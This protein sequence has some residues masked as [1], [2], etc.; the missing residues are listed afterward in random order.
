MWVEKVYF[1]PII[2]SQPDRRTVLQ[3]NFYKHPGDKVTL[4]SNALVHIMNNTAAGVWHFVS[5]WEKKRQ[6]SQ[7]LKHQN[8]SYS[9]HHKLETFYL[10]LWDMDEQLRLP[11]QITHG[12]NCKAAIKALAQPTYKPGHNIVTDADFIMAEHNQKSPSHTP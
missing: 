9:Y 7:L 3:D 4:V 1:L 5:K 11:H 6:V 8:H 12:M 10:A 2:R